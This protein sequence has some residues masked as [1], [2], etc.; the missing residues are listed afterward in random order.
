MLVWKRPLLYLRN[1]GP[2]PVTVVIVDIVVIVAVVVA[3]AI[4]FE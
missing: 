3:T 2:R 4:V 1:E